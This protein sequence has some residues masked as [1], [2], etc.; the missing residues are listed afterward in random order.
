M[1][2]EVRALKEFLFTRMYRHPRVMGPMGHAQVLVAKLFG[3]LVAQPE[4]LPAD[5][6]AQCGMGGDAATRRVVRDYIAGMTDNYAL[7]EYGRVVGPEISLDEKVG[8]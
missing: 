2:A 5:W 4:L 6:A 7:T 3:A 8:D 1:M